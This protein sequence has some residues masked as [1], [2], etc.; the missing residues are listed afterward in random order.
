MNSVNF[1][2]ISSYF[3]VILSLK[4]NCTCNHLRIMNGRMR[5]LILTTRDPL[6]GRMFEMARVL[7]GTPCQRRLTL[8]GRHRVAQTVTHVPPPLPLVRAVKQCFFPHLF[9]R[10][11]REYKRGARSAQCVFFRILCFFSFTTYAMRSAV[12]EWFSS[13]VSA[14]CVFGFT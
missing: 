13:A 7:L 3:C 1:Y 9:L 10:V 6:G 4:L 11:C 14:L 2:S 8:R 12:S 5:C